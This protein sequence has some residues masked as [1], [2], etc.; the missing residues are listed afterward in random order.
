MRTCGR[1]L[2]A[3]TVVRGVGGAV[4]IESP[5]PQGLLPHCNLNHVQYAIQRKMRIQGDLD[6]GEFEIAPVQNA[7]WTNEASGG[8]LPICAAE[9]H[10]DTQ[11]MRHVMWTYL[12]HGFG[13]NYGLD[14]TKSASNPKNIYVVFMCN[15]AQFHGL[16]RCFAGIDPYMEVLD[17]QNVIPDQNA[18]LI[19]APSESLAITHD[20]KIGVLPFNDMV[21]FK[22]EKK[23]NKLLGFGKK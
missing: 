15:S 19:Y 11:N 2:D 8:C 1:I 6:P 20:A 7:I 10:F 3:A 22:P 12:F 13:T 17:P 14:I 5:P 21:P 18:T 4:N 23:K 16:D 9:I